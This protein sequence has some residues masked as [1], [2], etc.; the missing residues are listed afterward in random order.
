M[1][2]LVRKRMMDCANFKN[3]LFGWSSEKV[4]GERFYAKSRLP[5][6]HDYPS[7]LLER[8][9]VPF[10]PWKVRNFLTSCFE[11]GE[12][13]TVVKRLDHVRPTVR[14]LPLLLL[15]LDACQLPPSNIM[16]RHRR[17]STIGIA[18][19]VIFLPAIGACCFLLPSSP[20]S[21]GELIWYT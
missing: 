8:L 14:P 21:T 18:L 4:Q 3:L 7:R 12:R 9:D 11:R 1:E 13:F 16:S 19:H 5:I 10:Q 17:S 15:Q 2:K 20:R 6:G